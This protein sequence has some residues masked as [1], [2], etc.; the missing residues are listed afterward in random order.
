MGLKN[1]CKHCKFIEKTFPKASEM[2]DRE[3][4]MFTEV[5]CYLHDGNDFCNFS[6]IKE[7]K[8]GEVD[9]DN[10]SYKELQEIRF[11]V[12]KRL[13]GFDK[14]IGLCSDGGRGNY[15]P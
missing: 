7:M 12:D 3:Y 13:K 14:S 6:K 10:L 9:F 5:F 4:W 15:K 1:K 2:T 11:E 8:K